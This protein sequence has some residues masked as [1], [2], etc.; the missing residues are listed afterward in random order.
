MYEAR[1]CILVCL[2]VCRLCLSTLKFLFVRL[3]SEQSFGILAYCEPS[4]RPALLM[5]PLGMD[6]E[7]CVNT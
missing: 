5:R 6:T 4:Y 7:V 2:S 3:Y 1:G